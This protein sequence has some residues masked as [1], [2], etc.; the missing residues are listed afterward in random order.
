MLW[1]TA[2]A[3]TGKRLVSRAALA[4]A[5][6]VLRGP[7]APRGGNAGYVHAARPGL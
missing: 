6:I 1:L 2:R 7:S 5:I 4:Q 3:Y